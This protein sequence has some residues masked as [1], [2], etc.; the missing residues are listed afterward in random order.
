MLASATIIPTISNAISPCKSIMTS[1]PGRFDL[2]PMSL[3]ETRRSGTFARQEICGRLMA[4][5]RHH[6]VATRSLEA[7]IGGQRHH[8]YAR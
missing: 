2:N 7:V 6:G 1:Q 4:L 5:H 8:R 3:S